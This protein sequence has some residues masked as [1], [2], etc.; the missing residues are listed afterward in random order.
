MD[1]LRIIRPGNLC[2]VAALMWV[3]EKWVAVPVLQSY[4]HLPEQLPTWILL[5]MIMATVL[6]AAGGYVINDYF[7]IKIDRINRPESLI[8]TNT[9]SKQ[10]SMRYFQVLTAVGVVAGLVAAY[11]CQSTSLAVVYILVPGLLWF[12]SASYK[13][14]F[15][16][17]NLIISF[18]ASLTPLLVAMAND[19]YMQNLYGE[20]IVDLGISPSLYLW[21]GGFVVFAFVFTWLREVVKD[22]QDQQGDRELE[23]H[24][25][26]IVLGE[27]VTK[28]IVTIVLLLAMV[29]LGW[30]QWGVLP[31]ANGWSSLSVRYLVFGMWIPMLCSL[32]LL[33]RA[34]IP[35][36]Y[37]TTQQ[38]LK[39]IM[40]M[41]SL[42]SFVILRML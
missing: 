15:I 22:L 35:S 10:Q 30:L 8:V 16:I 9:I 38:L 27:N 6:I 18:A 11:F 4:W 33:W 40:L 39:F 28:I 29:A 36:D 23:C 2:F 13:R 12:Y 19:S 24:S 3:M 42:Y 41:G 14:Q 25:L 20:V 17:G 32:A 1:Y 37:K 31:F 34:Q 26:P 21:I 5:L 7:D